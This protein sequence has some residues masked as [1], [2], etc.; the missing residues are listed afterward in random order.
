[1]YTCPQVVFNRTGTDSYLT[2]VKT[3]KYGELEIQE[4]YS[5][6]GASYTTTHKKSGASLTEFWD[7]EINETGWFRKTKDENMV[8]FMKAQGDK[9]R[10]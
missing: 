7:R 9:G 8:N 3:E 4:K 2:K 1:M 5:P 10:D 6:E